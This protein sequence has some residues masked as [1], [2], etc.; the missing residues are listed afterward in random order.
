MPARWSIWPRMYAGSL[1]R[2]LLCHRALLLHIKVALKLFSARPSS[3]AWG[4][5]GRY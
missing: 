3:K 5:A 1:C 4:A 2:C